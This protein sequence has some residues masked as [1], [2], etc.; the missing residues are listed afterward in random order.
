MHK[1]YPCTTCIYFDLD[2]SNAAMAEQRLKGVA[3]EDLLIPYKCT[4]PTGNHLKGTKDTLENMANWGPDTKGIINSTIC[5]HTTK[6]YL[7]LCPQTG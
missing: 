1:E 5:M 3:T 4:S 7:V 2:Q 6:E